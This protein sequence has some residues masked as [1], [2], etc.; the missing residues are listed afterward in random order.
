M[1]EEERAFLLHLLHA[2]NEINILIK[3]F[4]YVSRVQ[5]EP[6][7]AYANLIQSMTFGRVLTG[8]LSD[9]STL[10]YKGYV[11]AGLDKLYSPNLGP[12]ATDSLSR[13]M[14]YFED[15]SNLI[16]TVRNGFSSHYDSER[17]SR[18]FDTA[19]ENERWEVVLSNH[20]ANSLF[21][22]PEI[23]LLH[24]MMEE[25]HAGDHDEAYQKLMDDTSQVSAWFKTFALAFLRAAITR[26]LGGFEQWDANRKVVELVG[27][28]SFHELAIPFF[29]EVE[30]E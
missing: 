9:A 6:F 25:V 21:L 17:L 29:T 22:A 30:S 8:K 13:M 4:S 18:H 20:D 24:A 11:K 7:L 27:A 23:V 5:D 15:R 19:P 2:A 28:P 16:S 26:H 1:P 12:E 14:A 3:V 10:I